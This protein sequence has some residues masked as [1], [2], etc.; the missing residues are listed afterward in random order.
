MRILVFSDS[1]GM[2]TYMEKKV[3]ECRPDQVAHL[4]DHDSDIEA[5]AAEYPQIGMFSVAGNCDRSSLGRLRRLEEWEGVRVLLTHGH[6]Y[7]V[8]L[9]LDSLIREAQHLEAQVVLFGHTHRPCLEY[10]EGILFLNPGPAH[11]S[12]ALLE[13]HEGK[14]SAMLLDA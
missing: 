8:K 10:R 11:R 6:E 9:G 7:G 3:A 13:L 12:C 5:L 14:A 4:G 1:H 2:C